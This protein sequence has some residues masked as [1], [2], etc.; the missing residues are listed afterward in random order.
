MKLLDHGKLLKYIG[1]IC[2]LCKKNITFIAKHYATRRLK[3]YKF[4]IK[5]SCFLDS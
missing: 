3:K 4:T 2:H 1:S 5:M